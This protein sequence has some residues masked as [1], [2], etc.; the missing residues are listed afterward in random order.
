MEWPTGLLS[1]RAFSDKPA[2]A[3]RP[4]TITAADL[5]GRR[6]AEKRTPGRSVRRRVDC[7]S[8]QHE[9]QKLVAA[10]NQGARDAGR[11][12]ARLGKRAEVF[13]VV[14][15][16]TE[17]T[18]AAELWRFTGG[19]IDQPN[20]VDIQRAAQANPLEKVISG[21]TTGTDPATHIA[22]V[23]SVLDVGATPFM[24]FVQQNPAVAIE[25]YR[26]KVLPHLH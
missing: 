17:I 15:D 26:A 8:G 24:H 23:Q 18:R 10:F 12:P 13:A 9:N 5:R 19:A 4:A 6:R 20:P 2:Q 7:G 16:H 1:R 11:D 21:W 25:F 3:L 14:G 22:A